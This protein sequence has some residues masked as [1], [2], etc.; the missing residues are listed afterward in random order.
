M[1]APESTCTNT[2]LTIDR[3]GN[4]KDNMMKAMMVLNW[5]NSIDA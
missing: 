5:L 4:M 3:H 2:P 1:A